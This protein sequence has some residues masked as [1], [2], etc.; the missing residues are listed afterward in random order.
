MVGEQGV[1]KNN[2]IHA[3]NTGSPEI[4][5]YQMFKEI[6]RGGMVVAC[7]VLQTELKRVLTMQNKF[8]DVR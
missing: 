6:G 4:P 8:G 7:K 5:G 1:T 2:R 3:H